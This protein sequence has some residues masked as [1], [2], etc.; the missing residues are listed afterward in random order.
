ML[1]PLALAAR[2]VPLSGA[3]AG[4]RRLPGPHAAGN[5]GRGR[6]RPGAGENEI[7][8]LI[9]K[10]WNDGQRRLGPSFF[11]CRFLQLLPHTPILRHPIPPCEASRTQPK[12][13]LSLR[14]LYD[15]VF[16]CNA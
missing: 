6:V 4:R 2:L 1:D 3:A 8:S 5:R 13:E 9:K 16:S 15:L 12:A 7:G 11:L 10:A 14:R